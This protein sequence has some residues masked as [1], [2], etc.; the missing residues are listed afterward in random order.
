MVRHINWHV[1]FVAKVNKKSSLFKYLSFDIFRSKYGQSVLQIMSFW[2]LVN[3]PNK[4]LEYDEKGDFPDND[5]IDCSKPPKQKCAD[6]YIM[7]SSLITY[8]SKQCTKITC[9]KSGNQIHS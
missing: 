9:T 2:F 7:N 1:Q 6:G 5:C 3:R 4:C 8:D